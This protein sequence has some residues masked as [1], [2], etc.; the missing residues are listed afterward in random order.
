MKKSSDTQGEPQ[1][2][3]GT[4]EMNLKYKIDDPLYGER[5]EFNGMRTHDTSQFA[6]VSNGNRAMNGVMLQNW[7]ASHEY[8]FNTSPNAQC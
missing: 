8:N 7:Q 6:A 4:R 3:E 5:P 1:L 2:G